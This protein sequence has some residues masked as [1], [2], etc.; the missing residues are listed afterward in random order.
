MRGYPFFRYVAAMLAG[1]FLAERW[2][3]VPIWWLLSVG[4]VLAMLF[5]GQLYRN[6]HRRIKPWS[7]MQGLAGSGMFAVLG[8]VL[9]YTNT[10]AKSRDNL[11]NIKVLPTD[12]EAVVVNLPES[13]AKTY[14]VELAL[15]SGRFTDSAGTF[16]SLSGHVV[17]YLDKGDSLRP[18]P[19]PH[20]GDV[21][22]VARAPHPVDPPINPGEFD[23]KRFL[24]YRGI[25][26]QQYLR[27]WQRRV[28]G[29]DPPNRLVELAYN[30][31]AWADSVLTT[32]VGTKAEY[33]I[34]NAML[35]GV[36]DDLD[37]AQYKTYAA[38]GAVHILSVSG[39][40]VGILFVVLSWVLRK[41]APGKANSWWVVGIKLAMLWFFALMTGLSAP[42]LRSAI[43]FSF[44]LMAGPLNQT[45][46]LLNTLAASALLILLYDPFAAFSAGF[47]LSYLAVGG[48]G[49]WMPYVRSFFKPTNQLFVWLWNLTAAGITAQ[50]LTFP[51]GIYYFHSFPVWFWVANPMVMALSAVLVPLSV[52]TLAFSWV[53]FLG[54]ALG[55]LLW[56]TAWLMNQSVE[57]VGKLPLQLPDTLWLSR[58][59]LGLVYALVWALCLLLYTRN[60]TY[61]TLSAVLALCFAVLVIY[62]QRQ[63]DHQHRLAV[64]FIPRKTAVS[65]TS[66][67][68]ALILTDDN[69]QANPRNYE[70]YLKNTVG[71]WGINRDSLTIGNLLADTVA[72]LPAWR[73]QP[74][75]AL[76]VWRGRSILFVN[77]LA[78]YRRWRI[79]AIVDYAIIRRTAVRDWASLTR[80]VVARQ[81]ILDD[82]NLPAPTDSLLTRTLP[83]GVRV[84]SIRRDGLFVAEW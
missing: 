56:A 57:A 36:R 15:R 9:I 64:H 66:G 41:L 31:N 51:L 78:D 65:F 54:D 4:T 13:R 24:A 16:R 74:D 21:W 70:F 22:L 5:C 11:S 58:L 20:Y 12:Y 46:S 53:P 32:R 38:A 23:F 44:L 47:Q 77:R 37:P 30:T 50:L 71:Q 35:L 67:H 63:Q 27:T 43:M 73:H 3:A 10:A 55:W 84:H 81:V 69:W 60:R 1:I 49:A 25:Y 29:H 72:T 79:P 39:L 8:W 28:L 34:V 6:A 61:L 33:G 62:E 68:S 17:A 45:Q 76:A 48:I 7:T 82:S 59:G 52:A 80:R 75:M 83:P 14:K 40:H 2:P 26:H 42:V 19:A 18:T